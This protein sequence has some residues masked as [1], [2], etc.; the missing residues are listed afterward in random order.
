MMIGKTLLTMVTIIKINENTTWT[1][2]FLH[3]KKK[4]NIKV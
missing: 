3:Q 1:E 2:L 4:N